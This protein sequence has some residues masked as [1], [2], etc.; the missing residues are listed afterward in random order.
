M[1]AALAKLIFFRAAFAQAHCQGDQIWDHRM[2]VPALGSAPSMDLASWRRFRGAG[3]RSSER[4]PT[5]FFGTL[6]A[7]KK[8]NGKSENSRG[9]LWSGHSFPNWAMPGSRA[10]GRD[11]GSSPDSAHRPPARG[12]ET[13]RGCPWPLR[14]PSGGTLFS[15]PVRGYGTAGASG[16]ADAAP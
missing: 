7:G 9:F 12:C 13:K 6:S 2:R 10:L 8:K 4:F 14:Q 5:F 11:D 3:F 15:E 1:P 16:H